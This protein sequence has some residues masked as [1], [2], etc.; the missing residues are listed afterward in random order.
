MEEDI[1][2]HIFPSAFFYSLLF[3][4]YGQNFWRKEVEPDQAWAR[5][6][7]ARLVRDDRNRSEPIGSKSVS[8]RYDFFLLHFRGLFFTIEMVSIIDQKSWS[9]PSLDHADKTFD[10]A[11][12]G[13]K[14]R[15]TLSS[16]SSFPFAPG[17]LFIISKLWRDMVNLTMVLALWVDHWI[18]D[19][20]V[21]GSLPTISWTSTLD[22]VTW[23]AGKP[24]ILSAVISPSLTDCG[25]KT[26]LY[27]QS[28]YCS[29]Q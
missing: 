2:G 18:R 7:T 3:N 20:K 12:A 25:S 9:V 14:N 11:C 28:Y 17:K 26:H 24:W 13:W 29:F 15:E 8:F 1:L 10:H 5:F 19:L 16:S 21:H 4:F 6:W 22:I 27:V 23:E